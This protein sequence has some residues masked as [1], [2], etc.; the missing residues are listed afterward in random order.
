VSRRIPE[1]ADHLILPLWALRHRRRRLEG[2]S[3]TTPTVQTRRRR[4]GGLSNTAFSPSLSTPIRSALLVFWSALWATVAV[5]PLLLLRRPAIAAVAGKTT[6]KGATAS[7][8]TAATRSRGIAELFSTTL[9][10]L[11]TKFGEMSRRRKITTVAFF[12]WVCWTLAQ[13]VRRR[14]RQSRDATS[15][16]GRYARDPSARGRAVAHLLLNKL[17]PLYLFS[18]LVGPF[19]A[20]ARDR[21]IRHSGNVFADG[22]LKLGPLYIKLGQIVSCR[23]HFLPE[24]WKES[25]ER[26]QDQVP[27]RTGREALELAYEAWPFGRQNFTDTFSDFDDVPLAAASLGQVHRAVLATTTKSSGGGDVVAVKLQR[28]FL[29]EIYDQ[30]LALLT[31]IAASVDK[32]GGARGQV[33]G[34]SQS[35]VEIFED[36]EQILYREIDYRDEAAHGIRFCNDFGIDKGGRPS[37]SAVARSRDGNLLPSAAP[38]L[39]APYVYDDL[40]SEKVL[41]MEFVP[42]IKITDSAKLDGANVTLVQREYLADM[43]GRSYLRQFCCNLFFSTDPHPGSLAFRLFALLQN[44]EFLRYSDVAYFFAFYRQSRR[45]DSGRECDNTGRSRAVGILRFRPS[46]DPHTK[47]G[48]RYSEYHRSDRGLRRRSV[49]RS[50]PANGRPE[51][52]CRPR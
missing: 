6:T 25:M 3:A 11:S 52:R 48:G 24:P 30:D 4:R 19:S 10:I 40:S 37:R 14:R 12:A 32:F 27:A 20:T 41:V 31:K 44:V 23:E 7:S 28:P 39:R 38:W 51:G 9:R 50:L 34:V 46:G 45:R 22:L 42:C 5:A 13:D 1:F 17:V 18:K 36:A 35:W 16:W 33:G 2:T 47:S 21:L 49:D 26:L 29:R 8:T 15:E 43:L